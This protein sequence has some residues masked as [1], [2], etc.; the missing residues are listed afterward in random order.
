[1]EERKA[2]GLTDEPVDKVHSTAGSLFILRVM[3]DFTH[4]WLIL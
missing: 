4:R 3:T 2:L 1:M